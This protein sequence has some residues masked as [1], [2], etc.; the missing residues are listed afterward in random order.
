VQEANF[1]KITKIIADYGWD[2]RFATFYRQLDILRLIANVVKHSD[3]KSCD[4]L[5]AKAPDMFRPTL[6]GATAACKEFRVVRR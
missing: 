6:E 3:G 4:E 5:F 2:I 1:D